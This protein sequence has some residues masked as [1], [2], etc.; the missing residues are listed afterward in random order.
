MVPFGVFELTSILALPVI[1]TLGFSYH[2]LT[3]RN[4]QLALKMDDLQKEYYQLL[5]RYEEMEDK[6][7]SA[8]S[9]NESLK[10]AEVTTNLQKPRLQV[11]S[12]TTTTKQPKDKYQ[13]IQ[14]LS[15]S[16]MAAE[17]IGNVLSISS[18]EAQQ[19]MNLAKLANSH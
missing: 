1:A 4:K 5:N 12:S 9:F 13:Y 2:L 19:L 18:H 10:S 6:L 15:G 3:T 16:G 17:E 8:K 11:Q 14:S 7:D